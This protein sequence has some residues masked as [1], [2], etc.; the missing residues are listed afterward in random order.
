M[1][2]FVETCNHYNRQQF[3]NFRDFAWLYTTPLI[4][5]RL[6]AAAAG[7]FCRLPYK[8]VVCQRSASF[9]DHARGFHCAKPN[10][11]FSNNKQSRLPILFLPQ[12]LMQTTVRRADICISIF[13][14]VDLPLPLTCIALD[15]S[16]CLP[17]R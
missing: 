17:V 13:S 5:N 8:A 14:S 2:P 1:S 9:S 3:S 11:T 10:I 16:L 7:W 4:I 6:S 15:P 12:P